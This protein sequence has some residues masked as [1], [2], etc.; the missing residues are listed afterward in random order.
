M[1]FE[2]FVNMIE[3]FLTAL[4]LVFVIFGWIIPYRQNLRIEA[5][6]KNADMELRQ[7]QWEKEQIDKQI[8]D[9]YGPISAL[10]QEQQV[11]FERVLYMLGRR[12]VFS[13]DQFQLND[14]PEREQKIWVHFVDTYHIPINNK[15]VE[16]IRNKK[17]LIYRSEI[18]TCFKTYLDYALGWE[19]LDNQKRSNVPNNYEYFYS[20]N[21]P[22]EFINY[23]NNTLN[24]L[25]ER[26]AELIGDSGLEAT[27][28]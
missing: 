19:F 9:F 14:L 28:F 8:A 26:Q 3:L 21:F 10:L 27:A 24:V 2:Q 22:S 12:Y 7:K 13:K 6:R 25:L 15:I 20:F 17:H 1:N 11:I 16:I 18:P 23:I 4:G 5:K